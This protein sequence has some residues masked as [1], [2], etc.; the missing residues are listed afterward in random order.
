[1]IILALPFLVIILWCLFFFFFISIKASEDKHDSEVSKFWLKFFLSSFGCCALG[2]LLF[3]LM[4]SN[5]LFPS[6]IENTVLI[7]SGGF[8]GFLFGAVYV[9]VNHETKKN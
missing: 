8:I 6:I 7:Y 3:R 2:T 1:M 5:E 4:R 9:L